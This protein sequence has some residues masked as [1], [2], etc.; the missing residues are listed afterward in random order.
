METASEPPSLDPRAVLMRILDEQ[1]CVAPLASHNVFVEGLSDRSYLRLAAGLAQEA[2]GVDLLAIP[3]DGGGDT[4]EVCVPLK[5]DSGGRGGIPQLVR[6]AKELKPFF[7]RFSLPAGLVFVVD[8]DDAGLQGKNEIVSTGYDSNRHTLSIDPREHPTAPRVKQLVIEDL[9]GLRL[10]RQ[11]F[12]GGKRTCRVEYVE[13]MPIRFE[14]LGNSKAEFGQ[15]VATKAQFDD[16]T[17]LVQL[18]VRIRRTL[19]FPT[20]PGVG[21]AIAEATV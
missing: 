19:G 11:F 14:W 9:V 15:F 6:L 17:E 8:H 5:P 1:F 3:S 18:L 4:L 2:L 20:H 12:E 21:A 13:G 10:H 7:F 16:V